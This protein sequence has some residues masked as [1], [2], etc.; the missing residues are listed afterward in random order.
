MM[1]RLKSKIPV[2]QAPPLSLHSQEKVQKSA[3]SKWVYLEN[4]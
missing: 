1:L 4:S 3:H 2:M